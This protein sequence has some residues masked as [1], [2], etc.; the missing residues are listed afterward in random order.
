MDNRWSDKYISVNPECYALRFTLDNLPNIL[1]WLGDSF[2]ALTC[3][4][5]ID[6]EGIHIAYK[7]SESENFQ[8]SFRSMILAVWQNE[9]KKDTITVVG[10]NDWLIHDD[11]Y[12]F[13]SLND[14]T[15]RRIYRPDGDDELD[16]D[17]R[18]KLY[19]FLGE[20]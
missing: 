17:P 1:S 13:H 15:F 16:S 18:F 8:T 10:Y 3:G 12:G 6:I 7:G 20:A 14:E 4:R 9:T 2:Y 5:P 11:M 19:D